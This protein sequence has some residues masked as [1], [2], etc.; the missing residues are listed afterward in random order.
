MVSDAKDSVAS[1]LEKA[2]YKANDAVEEVE[3]FFTEDDV[4]V[5]A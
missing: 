1:S 5:E 4:N 2:W 3:E